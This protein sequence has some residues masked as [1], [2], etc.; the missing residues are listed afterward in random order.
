MAEIIYKELSYQL[1]G[2]F[3]S[4]YNAM[5]NI[6]SE[7]QYQDALEA[8]LKREKLKY[9]R[10]K[11]LF[12]S[13]EDCKIK[14]NKADFMVENKIVIDLKVKKYITRKDYKQMLRYLRAGNYKLGLIVN[15]GSANKVVVKRVITS[16]YLQNISKYSH[17]Y[18]C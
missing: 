13:L 18:S 11:D 7:R 15:F 8:K 14:G 5:G 16:R 12:F 9:E 1:N 3:Y 10:E 6:Y 2:I 4:I 17:N